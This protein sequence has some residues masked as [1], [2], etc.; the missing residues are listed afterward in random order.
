[1]QNQGYT[2]I[3]N[4]RIL[5][6]LVIE[7]MSKIKDDL[8]IVLLPSCKIFL[9]FV[10]LFNYDFFRRKG[11]SEGGIFCC[12]VLPHLAQIMDTRIFISWKI[13]ISRTLRYYCFPSEVY[14]VMY[15]KTSIR[16]YILRIYLTFISHLNQFNILVNI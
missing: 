5:L 10:K 12:L 1:M 2:M 15:Q 16:K 13:C 7:K 9:L 6:Y 4:S 14:L 11:A 8:Q 3:N